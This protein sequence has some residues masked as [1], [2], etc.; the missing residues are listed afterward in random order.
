M[1]FIS[2]RN[3]LLWPCGCEGVFNSSNMLFFAT[4]MDVEFVEVLKQGAEWRSFGHLGE[5]V[6]ILGKALAAIAV[7]AVGAGNVGMGVIDIT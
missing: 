1:F 2:L 7:L 6:H 3:W 4:E 5:G